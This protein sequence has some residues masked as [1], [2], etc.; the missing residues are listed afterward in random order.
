MDV[1][2][3]ALYTTQIG[4]ARAFANTE[5]VRQVKVQ[6]VCCNTVCPTTQDDTEIESDGA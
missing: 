4:M 5:D 6:Q 1:T 3:L 2:V